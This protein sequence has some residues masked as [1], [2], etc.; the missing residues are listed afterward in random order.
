VAQYDGAYKISRGLWKKY[1]DGRVIDTPITEMGFAGI[2][3]GAALMGLRPVC[4]FMTFNFSMQAIDH[5]VNSAAKM[6]YMSAGL[7]AVPVVFRG[8]NGAASGVG[9]QHSQCFGAWYSSCPGL[10][11]ISPYSAED[12][13]GLL[14]AAIRDPDPV[15]CLENELLYGTTFEVPDEVLKSDFVLPIGKAKIERAGKDVTIVSHSKGVQTALAAAAELAKQG[16]E[17]E[18]VNLRTLRP[19][20]FKVSSRFINHSL[21]NYLAHLQTGF[22]YFELI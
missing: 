3:V 15:I 2:A 4:E 10:K 9:A 16:V 13:K 11:V 18:V 1:G 6:L 21:R 5:V 7:F 12:A 19:L 20:D 14:K 8:P 22:S 17:A